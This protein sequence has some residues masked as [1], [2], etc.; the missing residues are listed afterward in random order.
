MAGESARSVSSWKSLLIVLTIAGTLL[1][2]YDTA[3]Q[4]VVP[5]FGDPGFDVKPGSAAGTIEVIAV[6][7]GSRAHAAGLQAGDRI[8]VT[9]LDWR[10]RTNLPGLSAYPIA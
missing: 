5:N 9:S 2:L 1:T 7:P 4:W 3:I 6:D 8:D 10:E